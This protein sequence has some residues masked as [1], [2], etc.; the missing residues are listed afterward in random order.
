MKL[1]LLSWR[2]HRQEQFHY[3]FLL[4]VFLLRILKRD[5]YEQQ[6]HLCRE[7]SG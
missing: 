3:I 2:I 6:E 4:N 1:L 7:F 5:Q